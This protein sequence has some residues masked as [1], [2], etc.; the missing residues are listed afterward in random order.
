LSFFIFLGWLVLSH[1]YT[2]RFVFIIVLP[3]TSPL[4]S[5]PSPLFPRPL[6]L[7]SSYSPSSLSPH[8]SPPYSPFP[9]YSPSPSSPPFLLPNPIIREMDITIMICERDENQKA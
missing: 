4:S 8:Y 1:C 9:S 7:S 6:S 5:F 3:L 2:F